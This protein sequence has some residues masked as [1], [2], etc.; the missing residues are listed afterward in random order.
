MEVVQAM[1]EQS[2][3]GLADVTRGIAYFRHAE[4][5]SLWEGYCQTHQLPSLPIIVTQCD[6]CRDDL[7][8]EIE[9]LTARS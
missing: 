2:G 3:M 1:L 5:T 8:F 7:L 9:L 4:H 6:I